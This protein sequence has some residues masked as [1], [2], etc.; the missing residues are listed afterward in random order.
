MACWQTSWM[1]TDRA[2]EL[3]DLTTALRVS[4]ERFDATDPEL[5]EAQRSWQEEWHDRL[6]DRWQTL[7]PSEFKSNG[8]ATLTKQPDRSILA[9]GKNPG[10]D[11]YRVVAR[12]DMTGIVALKLETLADPSLPKKGTSRA[13]HG[14]FVLNELEVVAASVTDPERTQR[15]EFIG[16]YADYSQPKYDINLAVDGVAKTGWAMDGRVEDHYALFYPRNPIGFE[17]GTKLRITMK[18]RYGGGS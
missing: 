15:V 7:D 14:N 13:S 12:T 9:S 11:E 6:A 2:R 17:G 4:Q 8:G 3:D 18:Q 10:T 1:R 5:D 16:A